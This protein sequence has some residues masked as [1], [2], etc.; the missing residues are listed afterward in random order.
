M[1]EWG[2]LG[3]LAE[4][5][6]RARKNKMLD[7]YLMKGMDVYCNLQ[8]EECQGGME[9][10]RRLPFQYFISRNLIPDLCVSQLL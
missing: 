10:K 1:K 8:A 7:I 2:L 9:K 4:L 3:S 6:F 5:Y